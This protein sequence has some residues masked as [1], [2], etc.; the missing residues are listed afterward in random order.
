MKDKIKM[1]KHIMDEYPETA[2]TILMHLSLG[3]TVKICDNDKQCTKC[4][5]SDQC[6]DLFRT[7]TVQ[8]YSTELPEIK[9]AFPEYFV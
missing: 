6:T 2:D 5:V 9:M 4:R 7:H 8:V 1:F 3:D